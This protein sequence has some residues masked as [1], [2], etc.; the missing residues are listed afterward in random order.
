MFDC[1][2][3][4]NGKKRNANIFQMYYIQNEDHTTHTQMCH[5]FHVLHNFGRFHGQQMLRG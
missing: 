3:G 5:F 4:G 1:E 2:R